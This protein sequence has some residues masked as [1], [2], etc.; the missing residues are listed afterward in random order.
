V[1]NDAAG[2]PFW[3][4]GVVPMLGFN[5]DLVAPTGGTTVDGSSL[6]GSGFPAGPG[7]TVTFSQAGSFAFYCAIHP[8]MRGM[9]KVLPASKPGQ[10]AE[11]QAA[12]AQKQIERQQ[13]AVRELD[14]HVDSIPSTSSRVLVG[15]GTRHFTLLGF[16]PET[17][18]AHVGE[19]VRFRWDGENE[20]HTVTFG[21]QELIDQLRG[22]LFGPVFDPVGALP[23]EPPASGVPTLTQ[24]THGNGFLNSGLL[25]DNSPG[26]GP[27]WSVR[28][29]Q[30]GSYHF[31]CLIHPTM[32]GD[33]VVS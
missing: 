30:A 16:Y 7:F 31:E 25:P 32:R 21:S 11:Q 17:V 6:V 2:N 23:S 9:V 19:T 5:P 22:S 18:Q 4:G 12:R 14:E 3:W 8:R 15:P 29:G 33:V 26:D 1:T 27:T 13:Q 28:F 10:S 24:D 20:V